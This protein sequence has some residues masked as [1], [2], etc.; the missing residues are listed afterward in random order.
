MNDTIEGIKQQLAQLKELHATGV[1]PDAE[2]AEGK[3]T[4][5]RRILDLVLSAQPAPA[6]APTASTN[7]V[8]STSSTSASS[9]TKPTAPVPAGTTAAKP[10]G[11]L[12]LGLAVGVV[13]IA[14]A[15]YLWKGTPPQSAAEGDA[16]QA[17]SAD[18]QPAPHATNS[19]QIAAMTEKLAARLTDKADDVDRFDVLQVEQKGVRTTSRLL[20]LSDLNGRDRRPRDVD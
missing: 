2:F 16:P 20:N 11:L 9:A 3:A 1:L 4:L 10:S 19:D 14:A 7:S 13:A 12:L 6:A 5:E 17:Q 8:S 15:G 18:G